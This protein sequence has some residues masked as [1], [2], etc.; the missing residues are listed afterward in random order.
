MHWKLG[1]QRGSVG[2]LCMPFLLALPSEQYLLEGKAQYIYFENST[3]WFCCISL[4]NN[5]WINMLL[6]LVTI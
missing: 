3:G 2:F 4:L 1:H 5:Q 6:S